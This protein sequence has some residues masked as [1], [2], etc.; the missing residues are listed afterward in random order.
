MVMERG[1]DGVC[2]TRVCGMCA[3]EGEV[4]ARAMSG[5][6]PLP[7]WEARRVGVAR[8]GAFEARLV[9]IPVGGPYDITLSIG[10][11]K[12][13]VRDVLVGDVWILAG[14][15]N[16]QGCAYFP[17]DPIGEDPLVRAFY[18]DDRWGVARD[19]LHQLHDAVD[20]VHSTIWGRRPAV[21]PKFRGVGPGVAFAQRLRQL[22]GIPQGVIACAHGG[23]TIAQWLPNEESEKQE[24]GSTLYG[25]MMRRISRN[26]PTRRVV[27]LF[28][29]QGCNDA[30]ASL[31]SE[32]RERTERFFQSVRKDL[33]PLPIVMAQIGRCVADVND[34]ANDLWSRIR[35]EQRLLS[36]VVSR[37][38]LV[39]TID[40]E[41]D[42]GVHL[43][44][45]AQYEVGR[46]AAEA[47]FALTHPREADDKRLAKAISLRSATV[48]E[49]RLGAVEIVTSFANV[50][51]ELRS[52]GLPRGFSLHFPKTGKRGFVCNVALR[53]NK[54]HIRCMATMAQIREGASLFYGYGADPACT[55][56]DGAHR[57]LPAFGPVPVG[58]TTPI[59]NALWPDGPREEEAQNGKY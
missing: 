34:P 53:G 2:A 59:N 13:T 41:L 43:S 4:N 23:T 54:A 18:M 38:A 31:V 29:F 26:A 15:S 58:F 30:A 14:Q 49:Y 33:G 36:R 51:G 1:A 25:A 6:T 56:V 11:E 28:W 17:D 40:L 9:G 50:I 48:R 8:R 5:G 24:T 35:E 10:R 7:G 20:P 47:A 52:E 32:F 42:E 39:P 55:I 3:G 45:T 37:L 57:S 27:G 44:G 22:S 16:M 12:V 19:P 21:Q 46:R